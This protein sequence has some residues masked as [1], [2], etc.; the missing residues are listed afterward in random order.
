[1]DKLTTDERE[2]LTT[3]EIPGL[4][5]TFGLYA[6]RGE[7]WKQLLLLV[8]L[9]QVVQ[10]FFAAIVYKFIIPNRGTMGAY[11]L[12]WGVIMPLSLWIPFEMLEALGVYNQILK[13]VPTTIPMS[14]FFRTIEAIYD[15]SPPVVE[16]S[17]M[18]YCTYYTSTIHHIWDAKTNSRLRVTASEFL[19]NLLR[20]TYYFHWVS[21]SL[22]FMMHFDFSPFES[23]VVLDDFHFNLDLLKPAHIANTYLLCIHVYFHLLVGFELTN[24]GE[25]VKGYRC[26]PTFKNPLW[27]SRSITDF[28]G[29]NWNLM[30][31]NIL[32][33][34]CFQPARKFVSTPVAVFISFAVSGL[35]HDYVW[36]VIF[37]HYRDQRDEK[38]GVC[39]DCFTPTPLKLTAFFAWCGLCMVLERPLGKLPPFTWFSQFLPV[40][41]LSTLV[42]L[43]ALPVSH[44]YTGD[45]AMS[46]YFSDFALALWHI[47]KL[48]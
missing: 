13:L 2:P 6:P 29:C 1:M 42:L 23:P 44:W 30:I 37:Y 47:K 15:T 19:Y 21:L 5:G 33:G 43:T 9:G 12:G 11:L 10:V 35:M 45:W 36:A 16:S 8:T 20:V 7:V 27:D 46:G 28:W 40:P 25:N 14:I 41:I 48:S 24:F 38:A 34:G 4:E 31:H 32:K 17:L 26:K 22:S 39:L 3:F 18:N